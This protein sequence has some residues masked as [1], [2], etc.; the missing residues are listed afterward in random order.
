MFLLPQLKRKGY[1]KHRTRDIYYILSWRREGN[2]TGKEHN[3][4]FI[5]SDCECSH[6]FMGLHGITNIYVCVYACMDQR[7]QCMYHQLND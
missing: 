5:L 6:E 4:T 2:M 7:R 3:Y 1:N